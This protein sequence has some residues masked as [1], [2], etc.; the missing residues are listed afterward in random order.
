LPEH[1]AV[2]IVDELRQER[3]KDHRELGIQQASCWCAKKES[4]STSLYMLYP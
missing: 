4:D 3:Q 2:L 1:A